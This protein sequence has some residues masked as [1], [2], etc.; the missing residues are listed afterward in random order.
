MASNGRKGE[1]EKFLAAQYAANWPNLFLPPVTARWSINAD[2]PPF[3]RGIE[4]NDLNMTLMSH[5]TQYD[6]V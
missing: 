4:T 5:M 6:S 1:E 3:P 2:F